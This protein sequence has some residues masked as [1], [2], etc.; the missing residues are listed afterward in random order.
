MYVQQAFHTTMSEQ[1]HDR[2]SLPLPMVY[3]QVAVE[4]PRWEYRVLA[5][6]TREEALPNAEQLNELGAEGW[7]LVGVLEQST[8]GKGSIVLYYFIRQKI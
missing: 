6:D 4:L 1:T 3:E 7:S 2:M 8:S 5:I